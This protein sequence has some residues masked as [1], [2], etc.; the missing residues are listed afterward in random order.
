MKKIFLIL[1][2]SLFFINN[3]S[4]WSE[5]KTFT[6]N[7]NNNIY[8]WDFW[9]AF[10]YKNENYNSFININWKEYWPYNGLINFYHDWKTFAFTTT[11]FIDG[12]W[13]ALINI[14]GKDYW[15]YES[16][17]NFSLE[18]WEIIFT[19]WKDSWKEDCK[20]YY[21]PIINKNVENCKKIIEYYV[22]KNWK[23]Y[24]PYDS[25]NKF[26]R[27]WN[28]IIYSYI[29]DN[30]HH[31]NINWNKEIWDFS[32]ISWLDINKDSYIFSYEDNENIETN[33]EMLDGL[34][35]LFN[36]N[37]TSVKSW[38]VVD[39]ININWK[40]LKWYTSPSN[41]YIDE[42]WNYIFS[43]LKDVNEYLNINGKE[44][45]P[46]SIFW[47]KRIFLS[48]IDLGA[49]NTLVSFSIN[50]KIYL[51]LNW[52]LIWPYDS[53]YNQKVVND[54]YAYSF[55]INDPKTWNNYYLDVNWKEY[56]PYD[57]ISNFNLD[58]N[59][60]FIFSFQVNYKNSIKLW[61]KV[62]GYVNYN[63]KIIKWPFSNERHIKLIN[64]NYIFSYY[65]DDLNKGLFVNINSK[66]YWPYEWYDILINT[67][68]NWYYY[69][70]LWDSHEKWYVNINWKEY[71]PYKTVNW[72]NVSEN[73]FW[74][75]FWYTWYDDKNYLNLNWNIINF[76]DNIVKWVYI[77]KNFTLLK[78]LNYS[79]L[80]TESL[81]KII[82]EANNIKAN[83]TLDKALNKIF[84]KIDNYWEIKAKQIYQ[85][86]IIKIDSL[87][88]KKQSSKN[89]ELLNYIK[90]KV[91]EKIN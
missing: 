27:N 51:I 23:E 16:M 44:Y 37:I 61:L 59:W 74:F 32:Y 13:K 58:N 18:N 45:W 70:H 71:W 3:I 15:P 12:K 5:E 6:V 26:K 1:I 86:L 20:T 46:F 77:N 60:N 17:A 64:N 25:I 80:K 22:Y 49:K 67:Y 69:S 40:I 2:L 53:V 8:E 78:L 7:N 14:N 54:N 66:E 57:G 30:I 43:Y 24:W 81:I 4:Y 82:W 31:L 36:E 42:T 48:Q 91:E 50:N 19:Y 85:N 83:P 35:N 28:N 72:V 55:G 84:I 52:E 39:Y 73:W 11:K 47:G 33:K 76:W 89:I 56:W 63:W 68:D 79:N 75:W 87:L 65:E 21:N 9:Y 90:Y 29:K 41:L 34:S 10:D 88:A 62:W 38:K